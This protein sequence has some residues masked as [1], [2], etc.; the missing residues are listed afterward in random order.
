MAGAEVVDAQPD[1]EIAYGIDV[2][3]HQR[4]DIVEKDRFQ[5]L[6]GNDVGRDIEFC[7]ARCERFVQQAAERDIYRDRVERERF[8][9]PIAVV[10]QRFAQDDLIDRTDDVEIFRYRQETP[11]CQ[12]AL[13]WMV[14]AGKRLD[15]DDL[16]TLCVE[17]GLVVGLELVLFEAAQDV[18]GQ[19]LGPDRLALQR[20]GE[21]LEAVLA[22]RLGP[23]ER[24]VGVNQQAR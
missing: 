10:G 4:V 12:N 20:L 16:E 24:N 11:R 6:E 14:P 22:A 13:G 18:V 7:Q 19:L 9:A 2:P 5:K 17:Q 21:E 1:S 15:P 23:I 8:T 3:A